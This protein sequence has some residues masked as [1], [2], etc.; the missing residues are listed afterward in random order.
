M[1]FMFWSISVFNQDLGWCVAG[2]DV[3]RAFEN[4]P[5]ATSSYGAFSGC[6]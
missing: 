3:H 6:P 5:C 1:R 4:T 2:V